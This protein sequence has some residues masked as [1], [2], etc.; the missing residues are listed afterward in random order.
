MAAPEAKR[1]LNSSA[2]QMAIHGVRMMTLEDLSSAFFTL[3]ERL[4]RRGAHAEI[5]FEAVDFNA[6]LLFES[7]ARI[8]AHESKQ[9]DGEQQLAAAIFQLTAE[10]REAVEGVHSRDVAAMA[11]FARS[12]TP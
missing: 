5:L 3:N 11:L 1:P 10:T 12:S 7:C 8:L 2:I 4:E 6:V 9:S